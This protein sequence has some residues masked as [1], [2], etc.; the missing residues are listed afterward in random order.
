[1]PLLAADGFAL[2]ERTRCSSVARA[3]V[4]LVFLCSP[5]NPTGNL[6]DEAAILRLARRLAGRALVVID[7]AYIEFA[8]AAE[9]RAASCA[10]L[11]NLAILRTLSK[12]HG[13]AGARC[14][15]LIA[16][17]EIIALLR[18]IIPPYA[19]PQLT[20]EAVL[21]RLTPAARAAIAG[22][23]RG[24]AGGAR[25]AAAAR[26][27]GCRAS[28]ESGRAP[29]TSCSRNSRTAGSRPDARAA[30]RAS[31][32][33]MRAATRDSGARCASRSG[34]RSRTAACWRRG[35]DPPRRRHSSSIATAPW[36]RSRRTSRSIPW[37]RFAS[38]PG[39]SPRWQSSRATAIA[40]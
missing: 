39:C 7:E 21:D 13:L 32:S 5:N 16:D 37:R 33:A 9:S 26:C 23:P 15:A 35:H 30:R 34:H 14:G 1:M 20:L 10:E 36:W 18:K 19:I 40:W 27:P 25:A 12:A 4:K 22:A 31:W 2:D 11:P 3:A 8:R 6:L 38:C 17:P 24:V 29:P 28:P